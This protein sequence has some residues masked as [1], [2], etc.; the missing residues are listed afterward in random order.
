MA[1]FVN[2][3]SPRLETILSVSEALD[4][5]WL[6]NVKALQLNDSI[7]KRISNSIYADSSYPSKSRSLRDGFAVQSRDVVSAT[8]STPSFLKRIEAVEMGNSPSFKVAMG[9]AAPI[10]TGGILPIGSDTVV[11]LENTSEV[12]GYVEI[13]KGV[14][15][16]DNIIHA[17]EDIRSG[18][19][20]LG[21][22]ELVN[23]SSIGILAA[24]GINNISVFNLSI[25]VLSTGD[26]VVP[27]ET[28]PLT[29]GKIRD[30]NSH[31]IMSILKQYGFDS[32]YKGIV[33]D[34]LEELNKKVKEEL[35]DCDILILSG[36]SSVGI[37]DYSF[38]MLNSLDYPGLITRGI[39]IAPGKPTLIGGSLKN[40]KLVIS[41]PG[42]PLS[43]ITVTYVVVLPLLLKLIGADKETYGHRLNLQLT[44]DLVATS[45]TEEFIPCKIDE[46]GKVIPLFG[47][48]GYISILADSN[49]FIR[50]PENRETVRTGDYVEV[51]LW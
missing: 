33:S 45:G 42:H 8:S 29:E 28:T 7:G 13:R 31:S 26:E 50:I 1:S 34:E 21:R 27:V 16:G 12:S 19:K 46:M 43:C 44:K 2:E 38:E 18:E 51:W 23:S 40:K 25:S 6:D 37:R 3:V 14:Q 39:N 41:L 15:S 36:G 4:F 22:G 49:G 17:G 48:S 32:K 35:N 30:V 5:P 47:K 9:E 11:M 20:V 24:L 10:P